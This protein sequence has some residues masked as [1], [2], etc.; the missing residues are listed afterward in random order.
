MSSIPFHFIDEPIQVSLPEGHLLEKTPE[1]PTR[2]VWQG[3][4]FEIAACLEEW[5]DFER[6]GKMAKNMRPEHAHHAAVKGSWGVGRY[7]Y[8]VRVQD[9]RIFEIYYDRSPGHAGDR[10]GRWFLLGERKIM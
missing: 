10:K 9:D 5:V 7:Y 2:F 3:E 1:C 4:T 8:R 6:K